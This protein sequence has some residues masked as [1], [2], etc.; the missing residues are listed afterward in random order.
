MTNEYQ[1]HT[2]KMEVVLPTLPPEI[3]DSIATDGPYGFKFMGNRW[4]YDV[5]KRHQ[6]EQG[7]RS[8]KP[9]G[10]LLNFCGTRT[11]HRM[12]CEVEDAGFEIRDT[13]AWI[14]GS[15][16][17]KSHNLKE[18]FKGKG[19]ALKPAMELIVVAR[20]PL[21]GTVFE[22]MS[23]FG[24]GAIDIDNC[25]VPG[26]PWTFGTQTNIKGGKFNDSRP[27][28]GD[29]H[30]RNVVGG[31]QG[32][33]PANIIHDGSEEV[34][35]LFPEAKGQ[36]GLSVEDGTPTGNKIYGKF[37]HGGPTHVPRVESDKSAARFFYCAKASTL[38]REEGLEDFIKQ[39]AGFTSN[40]SGQHI[41]RRDDGY[42]VAP[43]A[44]THPTVKPTA[45]CQYLIRLV[46]PE[47]GTTLDP[48]RGSASF[49]KAAMFER[50]KYIGIDMDEK[51][52]SIARHRIE[53]AIKNR[54]NQIPL[55][56]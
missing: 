11:Y 10:Y 1:L 22:N 28:E 29:V 32:R 6:W 13:I 49:G 30:A 45:L 33:W 53:F 42:Q 56:T 34:R 16:F 47:G 3:A 51:W 12:V 48:F 38:D 18:P 55:F 40:T 7:F 15:G 4:D 19:T 36:M 23:Q 14:Y 39:A 8:L 9:G 41:T 17:P 52:D 20:K 26:E 27:S 2:G 46:T 24:T 21:I 54:D 31:E 44:N 25:R 43:R 37:N 50:R 35:A 5:P